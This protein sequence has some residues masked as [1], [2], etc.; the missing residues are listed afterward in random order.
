[1]HHKL[2][3]ARKE[4]KLKQADVASKLMIHSVTYSRKERGELDFTLKE[5]FI[6]SELFNTTVEELFKRRKATENQHAR[7][8]IDVGG[9]AHGID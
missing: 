1:M 4:N 3:I 6:L 2:Y 7:M 9:R 5:A 8:E